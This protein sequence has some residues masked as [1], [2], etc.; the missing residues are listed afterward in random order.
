MELLHQPLAFWSTCMTAD[1][2]DIEPHLQRLAARAVDDLWP[3][4]VDVKTGR[5]PEGDYTP[6]RV[7]R[8]IG[9]PRGST[10]Y[11]DQPL[12]VTARLISEMTGRQQYAEAAGRYLAAFLDRCVAENGM[13]RWGNHCYYD[14]FEHRVVEFHGGV[15]ELRPITPAWDLFWERA[16]EKTE[17]YI[18]TMG[19]R[20]VYDPVT[21]GFNR[22]DD[23]KKGH[24][25]IEA[26]GILCESLAWLHGRTRDPGLLE[27]ALRIARYS[28]SHRNLSTGLVPNEPDMGRWDSKVCT[29]EIG[30]WAQSLLRAADYT[31]NDAFREMA[32]SAVKAWLEHAFDA[33][34]GHFFGQ[35][36][37][38]NGGAVVAEKPGY[39]PMKNANPWSTDQWP[40]HDYPM[41]VA[42][43]A[44]TLHALTGEPVF[45]EGVRRLAGMAVA[46]C[47]ERTGQPAYAE[48]Y[49]RCIHFL[50]RAGLQLG[51]DGLLADASRLA[52]DARRQLLQ[53]GMYQG[54]AGLGLHEAVDGVGYLLLALLLLETREA[55]DLYGFGF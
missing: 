7:Y 44:L 4:V 11:W 30:V 53:N 46:T 27:Q 22:H 17:T 16:P 52:A 34:S 47:P 8:L 37:I 15:H 28:F 48:S 5:Y 13:F 32:C 3:S 43:A 40:T 23:G 6:R 1:I 45:L 24:A 55:G 39:W 31:D 51:D 14:V 10:L 21:G 50:A 9:A 25:F 20:H 49:G 26:G 35:V 54:L 12:V 33:P 2:T 38:A 19:Q 29:S 41:A 36:D 18:R 42:E